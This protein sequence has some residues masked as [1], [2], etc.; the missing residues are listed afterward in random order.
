MWLE[1]VGNG[2]VPT[3]NRGRSLVLSNVTFALTDGTFSECGIPSASLVASSFRKKKGTIPCLCSL[4]VAFGQVY[5]S[6]SYEFW[7]VI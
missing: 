7:E 2:R 6:Q 5:A 1:I 3:L 4:T